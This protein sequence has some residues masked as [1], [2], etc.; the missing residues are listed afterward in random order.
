MNSNELDSFE[1][2]LKESLQ[3]Y[4]VPYNSA[5][6]TQMDRALSSGVKGWSHGRTILVGALLAGAL[7]VGGA[8]Y[9][10]GLDSGKQ[11]M[12]GPQPA[13]LTSVENTPTR[14]RQR[15]PVWSPC[16]RRPPFN[17]KEHHNQQHWLRKAHGPPR[18]R[19]RPAPR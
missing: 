17:K 14:P 10:M 12:T 8:A 16:P 4:E 15:R 9:Y 18:Q 6:W 19:P 7:L 11:E 1:H 5:H 3:G 2:K 13:Q